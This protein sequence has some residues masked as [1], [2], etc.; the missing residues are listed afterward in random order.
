MPF[1]LYE[2]PSEPAATYSRVRTVRLAG[3]NAIHQA[4]KDRQEPTE[5]GWHIDQDELVRRVNGDPDQ[6]TV[7]IDLKPS[8]KNSVDVY[9]LLDIWVFTHANPNGGVWSPLMLRL[10]ECWCERFN[11]F[12]DQARDSRIKCFPEPRDNKG[13]D[14][15][16]FLYLQEK[17]WNWGRNGQVNG[18]LLYEKARRYFME[19]MARLDAMPP[20]AG[21]DI[22][23][24]ANHFT[25]A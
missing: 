24:Q 7:L 8:S 25:T 23:I 21:E 20:G 18:V 9:E 13:A 17:T 10:R 6:H 16:E 4:W 11:G 19:E 3:Y 22:G 5:K 14:I 1:Y 12:D 15:F 2:K